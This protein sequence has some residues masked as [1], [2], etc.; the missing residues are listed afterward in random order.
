[1]A[2]GAAARTGAVPHRE[3]TPRRFDAAPDP[4]SPRHFLRDDPLASHLLALGSAVFPEGEDFFV[5]SVRAHRADVHDPELRRQVNA[6][7]GQ[8][9]MHSRAH[10]Q[11]NGHLRALGYPVRLVDRQTALTLRLADR[12]LP[13][14]VRLALTAA[15]EHVT[16]TLAEV[17]LTSEALRDAFVDDGVRDL[18][19]W[20]ALEEV[21]HKA[22]AFD[23]YRHA[24]GDE[25]LRVNVMRFL[26]VEFT[27]SAAIGM[28][29]SLLTDPRQLH[30]ARLRRSLA[31]FRASPLQQP[32]VRDRLRSYTATGFHPEDHDTEAL[33]ARWRP[34]V[35]AA[36][37]A[38]P[39]RPSVE[40]E[41]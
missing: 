17:L 19:V 1:V 3:V 35:D 34:I 36:L 9:A 31:T 11:L 15:L 24:A 32:E 22:V 14:A 12:V 33:A 6:F 7:I 30:P 38:R 18:F 2:D 10:E 39:P 13:K 23:V 21:E 41:G 37:A 28:V 25:A 27:I 16:A 4:A 29:V 26:L 8:E 20:H 40:G 5:R